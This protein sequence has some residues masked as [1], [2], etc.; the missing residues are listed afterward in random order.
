MA[1]HKFGLDFEGNKR[2]DRPPAE[3]PE[4]RDDRKRANDTFR[5]RHYRGL[6]PELEERNA[7]IIAEHAGGAAVEDLAEKYA[8]TRRNVRAIVRLAQDEGRYPVVE[9]VVIRPT[10]EVV[11]RPAPRTRPLG[12]DDLHHRSV[13][14][15]SRHASRIGHRYM[16]NAMLRLVELAQ[17][18]EVNDRGELMPLSPDADRRV[19]MV[20]VR[21]YLDRVLGREKMTDPDAFEPARARFNPSLYTPEELAQIEATLRMVAATQ[22]AETKAQAAGEP[23]G[24]RPMTDALAWHQGRGSAPPS[25]HRR[26]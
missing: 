12:E 13:G 22:Q 9:G 4:E 6:T 3:T 21:D 24:K 20:A 8:L 19:V 5:A 16:A 26:S 7:E 14:N 25:T 23:A 10:K 17:L 11:P 15:S 2:A 1:G 18:D